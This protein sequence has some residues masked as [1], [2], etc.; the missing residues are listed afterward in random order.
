MLH[1]NFTK[2]NTYQ[3]TETM[4]TKGPRLRTFFYLTATMSAFLPACGV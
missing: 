4:R 3:I 1:L 2:T